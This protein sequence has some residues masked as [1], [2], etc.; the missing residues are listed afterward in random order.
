M[1]PTLSDAQLDGWRYDKQYPMDEEFLKWQRTDDNEE[2]NPYH[3]R[4]IALTTTLD[5]SK[6]SNRHILGRAL[7]HLS[8]RRGFLSNRKDQA[9][10]S[11]SGEVKKS[12]SALNE[13]IE[14]SGCKYLGEYFY[15]LYQKKEK[16]RKHY[17]SRKEHFEAE[18]YA[19]CEKLNL[20]EHLRNALYR[21]IFYQRPLKSQKG[22]VGHC[23]FEKNKARC[24][25]SHPRFEEFRMW[26]FI[27]NI[28]VN[29]RKLSDDEIDKILPLFYR[30]SKPHFD[31]EEIADRKSV[32]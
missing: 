2:K 9:D 22:L 23:T 28:K 20:T 29:G 18:F 11:E 26:S 5:L 32:V 19:I 14:N 10:D 4:Y 17:T 30:K 3:D 15:K 1:C 13:E 7:Y 8:Q 21:A 27:N 16:I 25:V 31:F 6:Q 12:I 24:P